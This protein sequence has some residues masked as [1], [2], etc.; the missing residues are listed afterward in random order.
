M[1]CVGFVEARAEHAM[2]RRMSDTGW[3]GR[4]QVHIC[5]TTTF[6]QRDEEVTAHQN[7]PDTSDG[8]GEDI[9]EKVSTGTTRVQ[10]VCAGW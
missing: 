9:M 6:L 7:R 5:D 8:S 2:S 10:T 4:V 1:V 3:L